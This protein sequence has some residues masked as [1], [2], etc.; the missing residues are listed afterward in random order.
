MLGFILVFFCCPLL[1]YAALRNI[2]IDDLYGDAET[3][4]VPAYLPDGIGWVTGQTCAGCAF[5]PDQSKAYGGSWHDCTHH[6]YDKPK[7]VQ[8]NFTGT[9]LTVYCI[10]PNSDDPFITTTYDLQFT[11]DGDSFGTFNHESDKSNMYI[12]QAQVFGVANL[13]NATHSF[14]MTA[15]S[16]TVNSTILFDY[17][18]YSFDDGVPDNTPPPPATSPSAITLPSSPAPS[19]TTNTDDNDSLHQHL[20]VIIGSVIGGLAFIFII[21]FLAIYLHHRRRRTLM[22]LNPKVQPLSRRPDSRSVEPFLLPNPPRGGAATPPRQAPW[23]THKKNLSD[24]TANTSTYHKRDY[25]DTSLGN[26]SRSEFTELRKQVADLRSQHRVLA[27]EAKLASP[28]PV[29]SN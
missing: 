24:T 23:L 15:G 21:G 10:L 8:F 25:S 9:T 6:T 26:S 4:A 12:Y 22:Y 16:T 2:T 7:A 29:Y 18:V 17:A 20:G 27:A 14:L 3:K 5:H 28:L 11:I 19:G 13:T 1:A